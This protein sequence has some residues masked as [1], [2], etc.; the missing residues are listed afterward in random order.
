[1]AKIEFLSIVIH[2]DIKEINH[3]VV[4]NGT[5]YAQI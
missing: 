4:L 2:Q 5:H 1:M 3:I